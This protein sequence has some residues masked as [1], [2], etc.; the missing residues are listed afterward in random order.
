[1]QYGRRFSE[2]AGR[3]LPHPGEEGSRSQKGWT[4]G[5]I[6]AFCEESLRCYMLCSALLTFLLGKW[7]LS[8]TL[9]QK[10]N[11]VIFKKKI[12]SCVEAG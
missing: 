8:D 2:G 4:F 7:Q 11:K 12:H 9:K 3:D 5:R 10:N 1:M 6:L